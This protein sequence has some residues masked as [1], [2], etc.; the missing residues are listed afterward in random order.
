MDGAHAV[1]LSPSAVGLQRS[2]I[3]QARIIAEG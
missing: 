3:A 1:T 2:G